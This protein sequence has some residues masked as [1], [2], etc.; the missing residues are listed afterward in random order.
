MKIPKFLR[1]K[2]IP[3][4]QRSFREFSRTSLVS[5][6]AAQT[7]EYIRLIVKAVEQRKPVHWNARE[8]I[9]TGAV[10]GLEEYLPKGD[11]LLPPEQFQ[12]IGV[13]TAR[14]IWTIGAGTAIL[15]TGLGSW[16]YLNQHK[17]LKQEPQSRAIKQPTQ[18]QI[19]GQSIFRK[20]PFVYTGSF[21]LD[22]TPTNQQTNSPEYQ[23]PKTM[24]QLTIKTR[25]GEAQLAKKEPEEI[26]RLIKHDTSPIKQPSKQ[27]K[28][29]ENYPVLTTTN[30]I[31]ATTYLPTSPSQIKPKIET[32]RQIV[33]TPQRQQPSKL[34]TS[35][36]PVATTKV[37][38]KRIEFYQ[39]S[40]PRDYNLPFSIKEGTNNIS[41][42]RI[43]GS[44]L[45]SYSKP[46][47]RVKAV[48]TNTNLPSDEMPLLAE[49]GYEVK[50]AEVKVG[51]NTFYMLK[52]ETNPKSFR[53]AQKE[54]S[55]IRSD[56]TGKVYLLPQGKN[57]PG[58]FGYKR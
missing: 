34:E 12:R 15:A 7:A 2:E 35:L 11:L 28:S 16:F 4:E 10:K 49:A 30:P 42:E 20:E 32:P 36:E 25:K 41:L 44:E 24:P 40:N 51:S 9:E 57:F 46:L 18:K 37:N 54:G 31:L 38:G 53:L 14:A 19:A 39:V 56:S 5:G 52:D 21:Q 33:K 27:T 17:T 26:V 48:L 8:L 47:S 3:A 45:P 6:K 50:L 29:K 13:N 58:V 1:R 55:K 23:P 43:S 22:T